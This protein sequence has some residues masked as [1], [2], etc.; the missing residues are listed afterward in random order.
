MQRVLTSGLVRHATFEVAKHWLEPL[1]CSVDGLLRTVRG[2]GFLVDTKTLPGCTQSRFGCDMMARWMNVSTLAG[3][4]CRWRWSERD[5]AL[6]CAPCK[7]R[8]NQT[9]GKSTCRGVASIAVSPDV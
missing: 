5:E 1:G 6:R 9:L 4:G 2:A 8:W 7:W 3:H